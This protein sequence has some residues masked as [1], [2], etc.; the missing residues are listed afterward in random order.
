MAGRNDPVIK[1]VWDTGTTDPRQAAPERTADAETGPRLH[2]LRR[3]DSRVETVPDLCGLTGHRNRDLSR[4][5]AAWPPQLSSTNF[6]RH[7]QP[8]IPACPAITSKINVA[9]RKFPRS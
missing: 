9:H 7:C 1:G 5:G 4:K 3:D 8:S 2:P 6:Y